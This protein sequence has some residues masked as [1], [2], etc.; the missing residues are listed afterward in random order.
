M[1]MGFVKKTKIVVFRRGGILAERVRLTYRNAPIECINGF[2]YVCV[3]FTPS[4]SLYRMAENV[5]SKAKHV[6]ISLFNSLRSLLPT[7]H[8]TF[9]KIT[10]MM[11][12]G[13]ELWGL[14]EFECVEKV[15]AY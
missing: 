10:S 13:S 3:Y 6:F 2:S 8:R 9:F 15:N 7:D 4:L 1:F 12:Y 5:S 11:L 14:S